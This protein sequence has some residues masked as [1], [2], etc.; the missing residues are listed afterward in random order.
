MT[1]TS[2]D[3][4]GLEIVRVTLAKGDGHGL[5]TNRSV[6]CRV[7]VSLLIVT[8]TI[9][10]V[11]LILDG[12]NSVRLDRGRRRSESEAIRLRSSKRCDSGERNGLEEA[13]F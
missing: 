5:V 3:L 10:T 2:K 12:N 6:L 13:H 8:Y 4:D 9:K 7:Q 1:L 11:G